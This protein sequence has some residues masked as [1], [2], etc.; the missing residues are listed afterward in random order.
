M[1]E[2]HYARVHAD[3]WERELR[4]MKAGGIN[5]VAAYVFWIHHEEIEGQYDWSGNRNLRL[6][7]QLCMKVGLYCYPR[8]G[9][10]AHG[11]CRNGGFPDWLLAKCGKDVRKDAPVYLSYVKHLYDEIATQLRGLLWKDGGPVVGVQLENELIHNAPHIHTLKMMAREAGIDVPL[12]TMT[13]W[14]P[15]AVP[16]DEVIPVFGG[17]PDAFWDLQAATWSRESRKSYFFS[18][19]RDD[20]AIGKDLLKPQELADLSYMQRYPYG[21][22]ETGGGMQVAYRRRPEVTADDIAALAYVKVGNGSNLLGYYMYHGGS[23]PP[24]KLTTMQESQATGYPN[25]L[26]VINYDFQA[27]LGEY[28][29]ARPSFH[30]LRR[31]HLFI[32]SFGSQLAPMPLVLPQEPPASLDDTETVRWSVRSDGESGYIFVNNYQR[33]ENLPTHAEAQFQL[34]LTDEIVRVPQVPTVLPSGAYFIWP[35]NMNLDGAVMKYGTIQPVTCL[36]QSIAK[37]YV[38]SAIDGIIPEFAFE[39]ANV[40]GMEPMLKGSATLA[41]LRPGTNCAINIGL[42]DG[43]SVNMLVLTQ[44]QSLQLYHLFIWGSDHLIL[45]SETVYVNENTLHINTR[46]AGDVSF[47]VYPPPDGKLTVNGVALKQQD[48]G[49][50]TRYSVPVAPSTIVIN[51]HKEQ[52]ATQAP[53]IATG[54]WGAIVPDDSAYDGAEV[55]TVSIPADAL[56]SE[57]DVFLQVSYIGDIGRAYIGDKLVADDFFFGRTWEIGLR[58]FA[59]ELK[60]QPLTLKFLPLRKDAPVYI[61]LERRPDFGEHDQLVHVGLIHAVCYYDLEVTPEGA[62]AS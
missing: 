42:D 45:C 12:Y 30:A 25:D 50:F 31:L 21:T 52:E 38:F 60:K 11:E 41:G 1:G 23:N 54:E 15:A 16:E 33:V 62:S 40:K 34:N 59:S 57:R 35:V 43:H 27:P 56:A 2:F 39:P 24:G 4:K 46:Q 20:N 53:P 51:A 17:Y 7:V 6:L 37:L 49:I 32:N 13:G 29:Q 26:P 55:W 3:D 28:G 19:L 44:A 8:I 10:W 9:P 48:D 5:I 61:P 36:T 18:S 22:C 14:G 47:A 58:H